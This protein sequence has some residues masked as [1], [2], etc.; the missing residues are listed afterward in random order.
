MFK[1]KGYPPIPQKLFT[2]GEVRKSLK[3]GG[4][5]FWPRT[6]VLV[7]RVKQTDDNGHGLTFNSQRTL[8]TLRG[9]FSES[10][11][12]SHNFNHILFW[13]CFDQKCIL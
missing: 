2:F 12:T 1:G 8:L 6:A 3:L 10:W 7:T 13:V 4:I 9:I 11:I 5:Y